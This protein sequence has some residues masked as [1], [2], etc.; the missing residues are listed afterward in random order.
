MPSASEMPNTNTEPTSRTFE[1][2]AAG[3]AETPAADPAAASP[4]PEPDSAAD[5]PPSGS[6][7]ASQSADNATAASASED[8]AAASGDTGGG[9]GTVSEFVS[10][11]SGVGVDDVFANVG[12]PYG[13]T[14]TPSDAYVT[15]IAGVGVDDV[16]ANVAGVGAVAGIGD[17]VATLADAGDN[18]VAGSASIG[19]SSPLDNGLTNL[20]LLDGQGLGITSSVPQVGGFGPSLATAGGGDGTVSEFVSFLSGVGVDDVF[21]NVGVPYGSTDTPRDAYVTFIAGVGVDDVLANVAGVGAVAGIGDPVATV[22]DVGDNVVA[23]IAPSLAS[24]NVANTAD[25]FQFAALGGTGTDSLV[26]EVGQLP[27]ISAG[28]GGIAPL[29]LL[30]G[31]DS[32]VLAA[33]GEQAAD[34]GLHILDTPLQHGPLL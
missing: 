34:D 15:F 16:F 11:L 25:Q 1:S 28:D 13:S 26:G 29:P 9:D 2:T 21:A 4:Q 18:V 3:T 23:A 20:S 6:A 12:V 24:G 8:G 17:P 27:G 33:I 19:S 22:G 32:P 5:T 31:A 7:A 30:A 10:F 14:D